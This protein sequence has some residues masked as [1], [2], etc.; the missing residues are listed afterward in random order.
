MVLHP[1]FAVECPVLASHG[2]A[3]AAILR[4]RFNCPVAAIATHAA[5]VNVARV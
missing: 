3:A 2:F 5:R 1:G 4:A